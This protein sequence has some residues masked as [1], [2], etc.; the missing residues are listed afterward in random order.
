MTIQRY[1]VYGRDKD[2]EL[3]DCASYRSEHGLWVLYR[4]HLAEVDRVKLSLN[5]FFDVLCEDWAD[6]HSHIEKKYVEFFGPPKDH[7]TIVEMFDAIC[8]RLPVVGR[9]MEQG[10]KS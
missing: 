7:M 8:S 5:H 4:D 2:D 6:D 9:D 3:C 1:T 10:E